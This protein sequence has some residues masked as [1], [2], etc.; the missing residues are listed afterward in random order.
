VLRVYGLGVGRGRS[1][2]GVVSLPC[3]AKDA[4]TGYVN[5]NSVDLLVMGFV[6]RKGPKE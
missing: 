5:D 3:S 2:H 6:G 4:V 1:T